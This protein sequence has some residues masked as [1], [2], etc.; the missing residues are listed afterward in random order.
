MSGQKIPPKLGQWSDAAQVC[1]A[2]IPNENHEIRLSHCY[3]CLVSVIETIPEGAS[4]GICSQVVFDGDCENR[5]C[6]DRIRSFGKVYAIGYRYEWN[7]LMR[8]INHLKFNINFYEGNAIPLAALL[9]GYLNER[10]AVFEQYDRI[11]KI[12]RTA[13]KV[14][15]EG[16]PLGLV[17]QLVRDF[18]AS[19]GLSEL[20]EKMQRSDQE[21]LIKARETESSTETDFWDKVNLARRVER[22]EESPTFEVST[23]I[24]SIEGERILLVDDVFTSGYHAMFHA[25]FALRAQGAEEVDAV[26]LG[27]QKD[28][29]VRG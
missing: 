22:G 9:W 8:L 19:T 28:V 6:S 7:L 2:C 27:R 12:P 29:R 23:G 4:C 13:H 20:L 15:S 16:D 14:R 10:R 3:D 11:A 21:L 1:S 25:A 26:V 5:I 17:F 18:A 24:G